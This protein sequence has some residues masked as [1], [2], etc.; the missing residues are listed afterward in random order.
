MFLERQLSP[1]SGRDEANL[2][3]YMTLLSF[4]G[5]FKRFVASR[6]DSDC[7]S[8]KIGVQSARSHSILARM[9]CMQSLKYAAAL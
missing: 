8:V 4:S 2:Q 3:R 1:K 6:L 9:H 5:S 7:A